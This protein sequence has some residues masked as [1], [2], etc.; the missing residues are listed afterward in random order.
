M[1]PIH[2][3]RRLLKTAVVNVLLFSLLASQAYS[4]VLTVVYHEIF[5]SNGFKNAFMVTVVDVDTG[6]VEACWG[7]D[8][9][10]TEYV[11]NNLTRVPV[12]GEPN[13]SAAFV[14][15]GIASN[16]LPYTVKVEMNEGVVSKVWGRDAAGAYYVA[17][18]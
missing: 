13:L 5:C 18:F 9:T 12:P 1:K 14:D 8:C 11:I 7:T 15:H 10:G 6:C 4:K 3:K 17:Q 2:S 16:G